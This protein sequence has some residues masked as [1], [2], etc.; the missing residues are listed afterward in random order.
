MPSGLALSSLDATMPGLWP[1]FEP[2]RAML[3]EAPALRPDGD[4]LARLR[5]SSLKE[6]SK[7][8]VEVL[9]PRD[10]HRDVRPTQPPVEAESL[11]H[12]HWWL[13]AV[14]GSQ[15]QEVTVADHGRRPTA[16]RRDQNLWHAGAG[17]AALH[18]DAGP[19][20]CAPAWKNGDSKTTDNE[21]HL[22][23]HRAASF[24]RLFQAA[25]PRCL[26]LRAAVPVCRLRPWDRPDLRDRLPP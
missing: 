2:E 20:D 24:S 4:L 15:W 17:N 25:S 8:S 23:A 11:F 3:R 7:S 22:G 1:C 6:R 26:G 18:Q 21:N 16:L 13:D 19:M 12:Q 14:A 9:R 5:R 10:F